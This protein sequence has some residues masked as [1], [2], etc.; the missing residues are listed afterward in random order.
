MRVYLSSSSNLDQRATLPVKQALVRLSDVTFVSHE[1]FGPEEEQNRKCVT[2]EMKKCH[3]FVGIVRSSSTEDRGGS[4]SRIGWELV[5]ARRIALPSWIYVQDGEVVEGAVEFSEL[6]GSA[7]SVQ[8]FQT[9]DELVALVLADIYN[10]TCTVR[11]SEPPRGE[12][13]YPE[14]FEWGA[15]GSGF[16]ESVRLTLRCPF[17]WG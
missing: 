2:L 5:Q 14:P 17:C 7:T 6:L 8:H 10:W 12:E 16:F 1:L 13:K 11:S 3:V 9:P 15:A 4:F